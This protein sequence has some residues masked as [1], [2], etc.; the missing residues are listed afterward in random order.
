MKVFLTN[1]INVLGIFIV[2]LAYAIIINYND[3]NVSRTLLQS[4][5]AGL[6]LVCLYG[7]MFWAILVVSLI[8]L[9]WL[10]IRKNDN[11]LKVKLVIE[12]FIISSP[13]IYWTIRYDEWIFLVTVLAFLVTQLLREKLL[14]V[15]REL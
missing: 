2:A 6:I 3:Q 10:L 7:M 5:L 12:W 8:I 4:F 14:V 1:W 15:Q 11:N 13:F 9:D